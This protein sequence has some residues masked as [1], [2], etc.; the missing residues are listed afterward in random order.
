M[1]VGVFDGIHRGHRALIDAICRR[2]QDHTPTV[3]SFRR[4]PKELLRPR[5]W[6]GDILSLGRRLAI[7]EDLGVGAVILIDFSVDFS[8]LGGNEF[9]V[10][11]RRWGNLGY[12]AL[13]GHFRCGYDLDTGAA[14]IKAVNE[15]VGVPTEVLA[16]VRDDAGP[17][18]SSRIRQAIIRGDIPH[19]EALLGR[20][21]EIDFSDMT[22]ENREE[23]T[24]FSFTAS[25]RVLPPPGW[26]PALLYGGQAGAGM[27]TEIRIQGGGVFVP[28]PAGPRRAVGITKALPPPERGVFYTSS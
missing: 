14:E 12:M 17:V 7:F 9:I 19:A 24:F 25:P 22:A 23:G 27:K 2:G 4:S 1:T 6:Q 8:R 15:S 13:G 11:L 10:L 28:L 26:Y 3:V 5:E 16:P 18:S 20:N 21:V